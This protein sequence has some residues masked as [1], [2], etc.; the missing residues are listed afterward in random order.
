MNKES[1]SI[2]R[3]RELLLRYNV[4][5]KETDK[6]FDTYHR[7]V[8]EDFFKKY[9]FEHREEIECLIEIGEENKSPVYAKFWKDAAERWETW[10]VE[11]FGLDINLGHDLLRKR[12]YE[13]VFA[14][15][16]LAECLNP[17]AKAMLALKNLQEELK[18]NK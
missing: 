3:W 6:G 9:V 2:E 11:S 18:N 17:L 1:F 4:C 13:R 10:A 8:A 15:R 12:I 14:A 16:Q 5:K 7:D